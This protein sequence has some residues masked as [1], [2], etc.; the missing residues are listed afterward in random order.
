MSGMN[1]RNMRLEQHPIHKDETDDDDASTNGE[2]LEDVSSAMSNSS[3]VEGRSGSQ[4]KSRSNAVT[5]DSVSDSIHD[6]DAGDN[7]GGLWQQT[8]SSKNGMIAFDLNQPWQLSLQRELEKIDVPTDKRNPRPELIMIGR[9]DSGD[10]A[11]SINPD[12]ISVSTN[13]SSTVPTKPQFVHRVKSPEPGLPRQIILQSEKKF[14]KQRFPERRSGVYDF[15][16]EREQPSHTLGNVMG[17]YQPTISKER[18]LERARAFSEDRQ[19]PRESP[20]LDDD[21]DT[22]S[23][24]GQE[25]SLYPAESACF[26]LGYN[27][28]EF[29]FPRPQQGYRRGSRG[30]QRYCGPRLGDILEDTMDITRDTI[31]EWQESKNRSPANRMNWHDV[32]GPAN[33]GTS[34]FQSIAS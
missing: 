31:M 33:T 30:S 18:G 29:L 14:T 15:Y 32:K 17:S 27:P 7:G 24:D 19:S 9:A 11:R 21:D 25:P 23:E 13:A 12:D 2:I 34:Y 22:V 28:V 16:E 5:R 4:Q 8:S 10:F 26:C 3:G 1:L 6:I 20:L